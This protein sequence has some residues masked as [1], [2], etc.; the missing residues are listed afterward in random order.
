MFTGLSSC[1]PKTYKDIYVP[2]WF[3]TSSYHLSA[4]AVCPDMDLTVSDIN[5]ALRG[6]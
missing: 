5:T 4:S 2:A 1:I 6:C 3:S